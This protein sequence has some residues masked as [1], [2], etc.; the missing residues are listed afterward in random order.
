[1]NT[2]FSDASIKN[3]NVYLLPGITP[4]TIET[5]T[6]LL[7]K[8][9]VNNHVFFNLQGGFHNHTAHH[10]LAAL[11]LGASSH[12]LKHIYNQ[13]TQI[14]LPLVS[15]HKKHDFDPQTCLGD[16]NYYHDYLEFFK[17]ELNNEKYQGKIEDLIEDLCVQ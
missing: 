2:L 3:V 14:Q 13:Q 17:E 15:L 4:E 1:M 8:N 16:D 7:Q 9:H 11:G 10:L 6:D 12:T 5:C